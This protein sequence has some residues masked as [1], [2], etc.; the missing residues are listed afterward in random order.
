MTWP[1]KAFDFSS[2]EAPTFKED[3]VREEV[4]SPLLWALGYSST[5]PSRIVR[6]NTLQHPYVSIGSTRRKISIIPDYVLFAGDRPRWVLEAKAPNERVDD[7]DHLSQSYTY[8][9]HREV[10]ADRYAVC[11]GHEFVLFHVADMSARPR[12]RIPLRDLK[13]HWDS[14]QKELNPTWLADEDR[15]F[16]KDFGFMLQKMGIGPEQELFFPG[17]PIARVGMRAADDYSLMTNT[18][19]EGGECAAAFDF[20]DDR[21]GELMS[22]CPTKLREGLV[23]ARKTLPAIVDIGGAAPRVTVAAR[24]ATRPSEGKNEWYLP[25]TVTR[26]S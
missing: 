6:S 11:N 1:L 19:L 22:K 14:L 4:I 8:A 5:G 16:A 20:G 23:H 15:D 17:V 9:I 24:L 18:A 10:R 3:A 13:S 2:L 21:W 12:L 26:F 7:L 25:L